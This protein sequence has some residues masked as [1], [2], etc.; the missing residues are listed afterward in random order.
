M[1]SRWLAAGLVTEVIAFAA[2][3]G[4]R[5][6]DGTIVTRGL[7]STEPDGSVDPERTQM[8]LVTMFALGGFLLSVLH[9]LAR[10]A[11][12]ITM[13][14]VP[15]ELLAVLTGSQGVYLSGKLT[16]SA[17]TTTSRT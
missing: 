16:R 17:G 12:P 14:T 8:I 13:P 9:G 11:Q 7:L 10:T 6:L 5:L 3:I 4:W 15:T 2:V 1:S